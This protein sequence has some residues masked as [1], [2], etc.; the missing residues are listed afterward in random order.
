MVRLYFYHIYYFITR[1]NSY[2]NHSQLLIAA[3]RP[4]TFLPDH[5]KESRRS[6]SFTQILDDPAEISHRVEL[7]EALLQDILS[8][9]NP[10]RSDVLLQFLNPCFKAR[11]PPN[12]SREGLLDR[13]GTL[14]RDAFTG[15]T[16]TGIVNPLDSSSRNI[17][18]C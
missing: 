7:L 11:Y 15:S 17:R 4:L 10:D 6:F 9:I 5:S 3:G 14:A 2:S 18:S 16:C 1:S 12:P 8:A 13:Q